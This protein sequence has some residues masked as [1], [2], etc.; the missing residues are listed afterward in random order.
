MRKEK[1]RE[2]LGKETEMRCNFISGGVYL[3]E[4]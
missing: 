4:W 2:G 1:G 3:E